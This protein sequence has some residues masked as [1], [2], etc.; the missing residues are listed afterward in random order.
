[1]LVAGLSG[2]RSCDHSNPARA[3]QRVVETVAETASTAQ[4]RSLTETERAALADAVE[5]GRLAARNLVE[6]TK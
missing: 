6:V 5:A 1:M 4:I 3:I 2:C